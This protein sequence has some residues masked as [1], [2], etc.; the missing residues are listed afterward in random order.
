MP[1]HWSR[2]AGPALILFAAALATAPLFF[3]GP[4]CGHDF[5]FHLVS[6][7]DAQQ[8]WRQGLFYP[9]WTPS[10]NF[11]AGEPR[12]VFYPPL[13][14]ML[15][16]ALG[17]VLPWTLVPAALTF[18]LLAATGL[19]T[20]ALARQ[21]L[22][23]AQSTL[24][25]CM[26]LFS[27][28]A[29]FTAY[30]RTAFGELTGGFW[31][32]LLLLFAL[33]SSFL[34]ESFRAPFLCH[35]ER[36][37]RVEGSAVCC[38]SARLG[39]QAPRSSWVSHP[40]R[41]EREKDGARSSS[42][43][44]QTVHSPISRD[45]GQDVREYL[46]V[47][48]A[49]DGSIL[50]L[51]LILA[52]AWLSNAPLGVMAS[53]LLAAVAFASALIAKSWTPLLRAAVAAALGTALPAFYLLPA[54]WEQRWVDI[55]QVT[56][57]PGEM[58]ENSWLFARHADP[59]LAL[60][61]VELDRVSWLAVSMLAVALLGLLI[62]RKRGKLSGAFRWWIPL[63]LIPLAVLFLQLPISLPLWNLLP[64]LRFLQFPWRWLVVLEAPMAIFFAA[65]VWPARRWQRFAV[66]AVCGIFFLTASIFTA[67]SF[68]Q[69]CDEE[70]SVPGMVG[71]YRFGAGFAGTDEYA[72][73]GADNTLV[74][75]GLPAVCLT[76][77]AN[78]V[79]GISPVNNDP[80]NPTNPLWTAAQGTCAFTFAATQTHPE[81]LRLDAVVAHPGTMILRLRSYPAWQ[82]KVNGHLVTNLPHREDGLIAVPVPQGAVDLTIDW[83]A[84]PDVIA[85]RWISIFAFLL[86]VTL[87]II[88]AKCGKSKREW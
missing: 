21:A 73:P 17:F 9:H 8:S 51:A 40:F 18:L 75:T 30:E 26:A 20:R 6:W 79:L 86:L 11:D 53:Y 10:A 72:P 37:Q 12:F 1:V 25:G 62:A 15:G 32:P 2:F 33:R 68:F 87:Y 63:A 28:Y 83:I 5:D 16:A 80:E 42:A 13:T 61:D 19:A 29:L 84:T 49:L 22:D 27:G 35:P 81:H 43:S 31:I 24:A 88:K 4:S 85:G 82:I 60:H 58:I 69:P 48:Q 14:W 7:L 23:D 66:L 3:R 52:G 44:S 45:I 38:S 74:P 47:P 34:L 59:A 70:D 71:V 77:N 64:K 54:A 55:R 57:D 78:A 76:S 46:E 56:S 65:A 41:K 36:A 50:S 67:R 39:S